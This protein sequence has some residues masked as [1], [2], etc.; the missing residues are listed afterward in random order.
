MRLHGIVVCCA[1]ICRVFAGRCSEQTRGL[2]DTYVSSTL[3]TPPGC[4]EHLDGAPPHALGGQCQFL[5]PIGGSNPEPQVA[6]ARSRNRAAEGANADRC[7]TCG[8]LGITR[9][10]A[11][12]PCAPQTFALGGCTQTRLPTP[13]CK[14]GHQIVWG[15][16]GSRASADVQSETLPKT[17][18]GGGGQG[19]LFSSNNTDK[20]LPRQCSGTPTAILHQPTAVG[21]KCGGGMPFGGKPPGGW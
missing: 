9:A 5:T 17:G 15:V 14:I 6:D 3:E 8:G 7:R 12:A 19:T 21:N 10:V 2:R 20:Y 1:C 18:I 13:L 16:L 11:C 4:S